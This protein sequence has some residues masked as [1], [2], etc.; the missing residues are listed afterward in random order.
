MS[1]C[2]FKGNFRDGLVT[3]LFLRA[4]DITALGLMVPAGLQNVSRAANL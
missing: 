1:L 2:W 3:F 4:E